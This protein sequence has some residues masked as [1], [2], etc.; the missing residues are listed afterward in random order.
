MVGFS[1]ALLAAGAAAVLAAVSPV[2]DKL[3]EILMTTFYRHLAAGDAAEAL[4]QGM[5]AAIR[6]DAASLPT[7]GLFHFDGRTLRADAADPGT[8]NA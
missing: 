5:L 2:P 8:G 1:R 4:R 7:C 6:F 3:T